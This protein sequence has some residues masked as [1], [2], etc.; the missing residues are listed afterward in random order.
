MDVDTSGDKRIKDAKYILDGTFDIA[1]MIKGQLP[2][3]LENM[4]DVVIVLKGDEEIVFFSRKSGNFTVRASDFNRES[5]N[6]FKLYDLDGQSMAFEDT[7]ISYVLKNKK[8]VDMKFLL[9][10]PVGEEYFSASGTPVQSSNA[11]NIKGVICLRDIAAEMKERK[12]LKEEKQK[13]SELFSVLVHEFKTPLTVINAAVQALEII[14]REELTDKSRGFIGMIKQNSLRQLRLVNNLLDIMKMESGYLKEKR[15]NT[16]IVL[17]T[18]EIMQSVMVYA[19]GKGVKLSFV[20]RTSGKLVSIDDEKYERILLNLLS[21]AIKF[22]PS[23]KSIKIILSQVKGELCIKVKDEGIGIPMEKLDLIFDMFGQVDNSLTSRAEGTGIGLALVKL[24]V[25]SMEGKITVKS[26][27]GEGSTFTL[28]LPL[29]KPSKEEAAR[30][31]MVTGDSRLIQAAAI[32]FSNI[33]L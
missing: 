31:S 5:Y 32:E 6:E 13:Q 3:I 22:T 28:V 20:S 17:A 14:C 11:E 2:G 27:A 24:L 26:K 8:F 15:H 9:K 29:H 21:N 10:T 25:V 30:T 7:P 33:Y 4:S 1:S 19:E 12:Q 23:G 18:K 16:D